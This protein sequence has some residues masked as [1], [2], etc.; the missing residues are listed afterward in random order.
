MSASS[1]VGQ[2]PHS[3]SG[4]SHFVWVLDSGASHHMSPDS[5]SFTSVS[6]LS[7]IPVMT[8]DGSQ[9]PLAGVGS[10]VTPHLS[11]P[12]VYHNLKLTFNLAFVGQL[13]DSGNLVTFSFFFLLCAGSVVSEAY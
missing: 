12:N 13:C 5:S 1:F 9:M 4:M 7:S 10:V 2:L 6:P 11:I 8:A 3:S